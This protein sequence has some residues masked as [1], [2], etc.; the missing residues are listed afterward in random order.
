MKPKPFP[1]LPILA[2]LCLASLIVQAVTHPHG[3]FPY[4]EWI[5]FVP[6]ITFAGIFLLVAIA[7]LLRKILRRD[8]TYYEHDL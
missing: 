2:L 7:R 8:V 1:W 4:E 6:G 3:H 5:G